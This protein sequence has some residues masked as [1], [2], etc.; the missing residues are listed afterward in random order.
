M[1]NFAELLTAKIGWLT[2]GR[3][4][5]SVASQGATTPYLIYEYKVKGNYTKDGLY[6]DE[7]TLQISCY[8]KSMQG[9]ITLASLVR[10]AVEN[11]DCDVTLEDTDMYYD[12]EAELNVFSLKFN[13]I[14][15]E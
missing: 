13:I 4:Y 3:C 9:A 5:P 12:A 8:D 11:I 14:T 15:E 6:G 7:I 1:I 10:D 2:D